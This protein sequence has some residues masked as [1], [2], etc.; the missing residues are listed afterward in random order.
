MITLDRGLGIRRGGFPE[1]W[2]L[3]K[4]FWLPAPAKDEEWERVVREIV[5]GEYDA[6]WFIDCEL[7]S[8]TYGSLAS[9]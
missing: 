7:A 2:E 5:P 6:D 4:A 1:H 3:V 8:A 9:L